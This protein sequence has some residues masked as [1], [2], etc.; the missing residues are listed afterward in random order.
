MLLTRSLLPLL[1]IVLS[2]T[3]LTSGAGFAQASENAPLQAPP[4]G[5]LFPHQSRSEELRSI[6][7]VP[8]LILQPPAG[9]VVAGMVGYASLFPLFLAVSPF[10]KGGLID[11]FADEKC[12]QAISAG[13]TVGAA[14]GASLGVHSIGRLLYGRGKYWHTLLGALAGTA[15]GAVLGLTADLRTAPFIAILLAS[16]SI[17]ATVAYALSD[18]SFVPPEDSSPRAASS[19]PVLP[20]VSATRAGGLMGGLIGRF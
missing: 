8:R 16:Q 18:S 13:M 20:V 4:S 15:P 19:I 17:G 1:R 2:L 5:E 11:G 12:N 9:F 3:L 7:L 14:F 6:L 10:C